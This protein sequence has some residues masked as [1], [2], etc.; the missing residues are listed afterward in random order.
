MKRRL[1]LLYAEDSPQDADLTRAAFAE[2]APEF[3]IVIAGTGQACLQRMRETAFDL[4]LLDYRLPDM[5]GLDVLKA[6]VH[7]GAHPPVVMVTGGGDEELVVKALRLGAA[8]YV[9]KRGRY[10]ETLPELLRGVLE[11]SRGK[12]GQGLPAASEPRLILYVEHLPMDI[13]LTLSRLVESAP[14]LALD[15]VRSCAAALERLAA[16][17][18]YDL[19]LIDLR[20]PDQSGL[21][22]VRE[23]QSRQL[24]M[25]PF[26][27]ISGQGDD[28]VAIAT[29]KLGAADYIIKHAGYLDQLPWRID[30]A[31]ARDRLKRFNEQLHDEIAAR[32]KI[33]E[34]QHVYQIELETQNDELRVSRTALEAARARYFDLYDLAPVGYC[35]ISEPGLILEANLTAASLLGVARG[36]LV[37]QPFA[38]FVVA[39]DQS[40][41]A[42]FRKQILETG[43]AQAC[44]LR[45]PRPDGT[46]FWAHLAATLA[47]EPDGAPLLRVVL[48]DISERK[49]AEQQ[50]RKLSLAVEQSPESILITD[51]DAR[52]EYANET[53]VWTSGY[54]LEEIIGRNPRILQS[55]K[56]AP[57][58]YIAMW[59]ALSQGRPWRGELQNRRKDGSEYVEF[60]VITPLRQPDGRITHYV[61]VKEDITEKKRIGLELD[62]HRHHLEELVAQRTTELLASRQLA[63]A[64][65]KAKSAFLAN[66][67]HEIR[68]PM[69]AILGMANLLRRGGITPAQAERLDKIDSAGQHLLR[70]INDILDISKIEAGKLQL[71]TADF[72]LSA[73]LDNV[74]SI[75]GLAAHEKGLR[76]EIDRGSVPLWLRGDAT[77]LRQALLN[78]AGN[79]VK[80]TE[81]GAI[82][83]RARLLEQ[84]GDDLL[85]R[86]EVTDSGVGIAPGEI[87]RLFQ[88]FEQ[89]DNST[90]RQYGGTGLGLAITRRLA[91][92]MGGEVGVESTPGNGST[93]WFTARLKQL[94]QQEYVAPPSV[95]ADAERLIREGH[96]GKHILVVDDEPINLEIARILLE[97]TGLLIDVAADGERAVA[98]AR[99]QLYAAI[100][101]DMQMP[102]LDGLDATRQIRALAGYRDTPIIAI[103]ANAFAEDKARCYEAGM[104]DFLIKP[105]DP[106]AMFT[107]LLRWLDQ[108]PAS[109]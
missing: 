95:S 58:T 7:S 78:Y 63:D 76:I 46:H 74:A 80:F 29:M 89:A 85:V 104:N 67:S 99:R 3:E 105:F 98:Q 37:A 9:P 10:L 103:T 2:Q 56:C 96:A 35:T 73:I 20:M 62:G 19:V 30:A 57:E 81:R 94:K 92:L 12:P 50:I 53:F 64:A 109:A 27:M 65:N 21:D 16:A 34:T 75:I 102:R 33:E 41:Y 38:R 108:S 54:R 61:A 82:I 23:A 79:A 59:A 48:N 97:D 84:S 39:Q 42:M 40:L 77:R 15:V 26:L 5:D 83:L 24:R 8:N 43:E 86:F 47:H 52:I 22:F 14:H 60:A 106:D 18:A 17:H 4:L 28:A 13:E 100:L 11:K 66:M 101:M 55:G 72:A 71:E 1:R 44:E 51:L 88:A 31:I 68:T 87:A 6:L 32:R 49:A 107:T 93:F 70:I 36:A 90:T 91:K 25:P 45:M 69:N